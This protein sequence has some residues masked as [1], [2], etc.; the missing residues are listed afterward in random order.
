MY[1]VRINQAALVTQN[2]VRASDRKIQDIQTNL[3]TGKVGIDTTDDMSAYLS[4]FNL[5]STLNNINQASNSTAQANYLVNLATDQIQNASG[6]LLELK[7]LA[8]LS[9]SAATSQDTRQLLNIQYQLLIQDLNATTLQTWDGEK[10]F[11]YTNDAMTIKNPSHIYA[12]SVSLEATAQGMFSSQ[13]IEVSL[14]PENPSFVSGGYGLSYSGNSASG[15]LVLHKPDHSTESILIPNPPA[16]TRGGEEFTFSAGLTL[17]LKPGID[18]QSIAPL[19]S[20]II[21]ISEHAAHG[22]EFVAPTMLPSVLSGAHV[23]EGAYGLEYLF[24]PAM[25]VHSASGELILTLPNGKTES[26]LL[27][28]DQAVNGSNFEAI[29]QE[30]GLQLQFFNANLSASIAM[31]SGILSASGI[32]LNPSTLESFQANRLHVSIGK[33]KSPMPGDYSLAYEK[34]PSTGIGFFTLTKPNGLDEVV[35][36]SE[37]QAAQS[38]SLSVD[39][40]GGVRLKY[41][42]VDLSKNLPKQYNLFTIGAQNHNKTFQVGASSAETKMIPF[43]MKNSMSLGITDTRIGT[44]GD[45]E[46]CFPAVQT[47]LHIVQSELTRFGIYNRAIEEAL[48]MNETANQ[49]HQGAFSTFADVDV[50]YEL[51]RNESVQ[52]VRHIS[53]DVFSTTLKNQKEVGDLAKR[54]L[55]G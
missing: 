43:D 11:Q 51:I 22:S 35:E 13:M 40:A 9:K 34:N 2:H 23:M 48:E 44:L 15:Y 30:S 25:G 49:E 26:V 50:S 42:T 1:E 16:L 14:H 12:H 32:Q 37:Q 18:L 38:S 24:T 28:A 3:S 29:F 20:N 33:D 6:I 4:S 45:A 46:L 54:A 8:S 21:T 47:A 17:R 39:F 27:N 31:D 41:S 5:K 10:I 7:N 36:I 55:Q 53:Q 19:Q 52:L